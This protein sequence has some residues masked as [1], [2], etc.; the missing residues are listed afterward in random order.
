MG[1]SKLAGMNS[2]ISIGFPALIH[3]IGREQAQTLKLIAVN[4][5]CELK[6]VRRSRNWQLQ[7]EAHQVQAVL[8]HVQTL[9]DSYS[10]F[11]TRL[12]KAM[13]PHADKLETIEVKL[14]RLINA[15]PNLTLA[16]LIAMTQC[17]EAQARTARFNADFD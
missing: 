10:Y 7:G 2:V 5:S 8:E 3:R 1:Q 11:T 15:S 13:V 9:G 6:R 12:A 4:F 17:T 14:V 16:E